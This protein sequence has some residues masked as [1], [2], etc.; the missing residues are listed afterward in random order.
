MIYNSLNDYIGQLQLL[1]FFAG[2]PLIYALVNLLPGR[3]GKDSPYSSTKWIAVLPFSYAFVGILYVGFLLKNMS[4]HFLLTHNSALL[5]SSYLEVWALLS[6]LFWIPKI[7]RK[8]ILSLLH[9]MPFFFL[10]IKDLFMQASSNPVMLI[11]NDMKMY[12]I[13]IVLHAG[14]LVIVYV[15]FYLLRRSGLSNTLP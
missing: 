1:C 6:V 5:R 13:S 4:P 9:S 15:I 14:A 3:R 8:T 10:L 7:S 11:G 2:Y 12:S